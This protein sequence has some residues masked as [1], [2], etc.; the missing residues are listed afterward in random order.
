MTKFTKRDQNLLK[1]HAPILRTLSRSRAL[2]RNEILK[3]APNSL[4]TAIRRLHKLLVKGKIPLTNAQRSKFKPGTKNLI[5]KIQTEKN[6]KQLLLSKKGE[7]F[8]SVL[9]VVLPIIGSA[10]GL[11]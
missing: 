4:F 8:A 11:L 5:R 1:K 7:G 10:L 9:K 3:D 2:K 6:L